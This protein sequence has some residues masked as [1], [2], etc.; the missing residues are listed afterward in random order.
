MILAGQHSHAAA[1]AADTTSHLLKIANFSRMLG[2][3]F[4][5]D[6]SKRVSERCFEALDPGL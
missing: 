4:F 3:C 6:C 1:A 2:A 5:A